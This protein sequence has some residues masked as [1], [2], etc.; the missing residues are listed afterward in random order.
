M[1]AH[2][3]RRTANRT[4]ARETPTRSPSWVASPSSTSTRSACA[5]EERR[6][7][8]R[9]TRL[10]RLAAGARPGARRGPGVVWRP[11]R[12]YPAPY[13]NV[14]SIA[15]GAYTGLQ[16]GEDMLSRAIRPAAIAG[17]SCRAA[18]AEFAP[19]RADRG[20]RDRPRRA[21]EAF[22][23]PLPPGERRSAGVSLRWSGALRTRHRRGAPG[24]ARRRGRGRGPPDD[25]RAARAPPRPG[26]APCGRSRR[27]APDCG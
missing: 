20:K 24:V 13:T 7:A 14:C 17:R 15:S 9:S 10:Y 8:S 6:P 22:G 21:V 12:S 25:P 18:R 27:T 4:A 19:W 1:P 16:R 5:R 2:V 26:T 23:S 3:G 11:D